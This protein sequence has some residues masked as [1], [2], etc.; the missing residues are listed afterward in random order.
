MFWFIIIIIFTAAI[1]F[2][3][4][5]LFLFQNGGLSNTVAKSVKK[6]NNLD[7]VWTQ[8][9]IEDAGRDYS[10]FDLFYVVIALYLII[11]LTF[12]VYSCFFG[13]TLKKRLKLFFMVDNILIC[14]IAT[15]IAYAYL[16]IICFT[17]TYKTDENFMI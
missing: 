10:D 16:H 12:I 2:I 6:T 17:T 4:L 13:P 8:I 9:D 15:N 3:N 11:S 1:P 14:M 5:L 7:D